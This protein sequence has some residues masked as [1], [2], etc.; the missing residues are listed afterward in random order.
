MAQD[1]RQDLCDLTLEELTRFAIE[2]LAE[3][4]YR[5]AQIYRWIHQ[6]GATDFEQMTDL[7]RELR[8]RLPQVA[9]L[10]PLEQ[11][12]AQ[13]SEDGTVKYRFRTRD[14]KLIESVYL[15]SE[16]RKTLCVSTQAGCA[17]GCTFCMTATLGLQR[18]LSPGEMVAQV[19]AVNFEIASKEGGA[20]P[21]TNLVFMGMWAWCR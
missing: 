14:G 9:R 5:A 6:R 11:D 3:R 21:L 18:N 13:H 20:R 4:P 15:P 16:D 19:H 12:L 10:R 17:M 7:S 8:Q 2:V 1:G